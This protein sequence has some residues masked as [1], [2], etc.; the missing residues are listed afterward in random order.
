MIVL[1]SEKVI[2]EVEEYAM[3]LVA[4]EIH[5]DLA[6]IHNGADYINR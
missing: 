2:E 4:R 5:F 6:A 1:V 3:V